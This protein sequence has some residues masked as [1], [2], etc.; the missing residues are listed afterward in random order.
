MPITSSL[1]HSIDFAF[2]L[3]LWMLRLYTL[4]FNGNFLCIGDISTYNIT[5][6]TDYIFIT[7]TTKHV[8]K[9]HTDLH[10]NENRISTNQDIC[11]QMSHFQSSSQVCICCQLEAPYLPTNQHTTDTDL[12]HNTFTLLLLYSVPSIVITLLQ[13]SCSVSLPKITENWKAMDKVMI[14]IIK[15]HF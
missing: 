7:S 8:L 6:T 11:H 9:F 13:I 5:L 10:T 2:N 4:Q 1:H 12:I 3:Q 14:I 15:G